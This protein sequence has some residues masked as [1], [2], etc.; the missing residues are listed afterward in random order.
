MSYKPR[1]ELGICGIQVIVE[2]SVLIVRAGMLVF[3]I[4]QVSKITI[5]IPHLQKPQHI[6]AHGAVK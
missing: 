2:R 1:Q 5:T 6:V 3:P 4:A